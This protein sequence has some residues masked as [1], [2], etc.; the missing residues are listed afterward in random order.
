LVYAV[1]DTGILH[2]YDLESGEKIYSE[3][4]DGTFSASP[5]ASDGRVYLASESGEV[6]VLAAGRKFE[7]LARNDLGEPLMATPAIA[8]GRLLIRGRTRLFAIAGD[9][10]ASSG[11]AA[12]PSP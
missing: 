5:V 9:G 1:R 8:G 7:V 3:R 12:S 6:W 11:Q 2:V 4:L 10:E